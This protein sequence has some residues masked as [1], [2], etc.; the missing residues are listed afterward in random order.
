MTA[1]SQAIA[2][3]RGGRVLVVDDEPVVRSLV[4]R[5]LQRA[6]YTVVVAADGQNGLDVLARERGRFDLVLLDLAMPRMAGA[7]MFRFARATYPDLRVVLMS[8]YSSPEDTGPLLAG[9]AL[10]LVEKPFLPNRLLEVI[11]AAIHG[12]SN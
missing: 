7:E 9:G 2:I 6:G 5:V 8:G 4:E 3:H 12:P 10:A 1:P 11:Q